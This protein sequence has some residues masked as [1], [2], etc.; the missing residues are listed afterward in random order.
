MKT[1]LKSIYI[2][3][4]TLFAFGCSDNSSS[5]SSGSTVTPQ[6]AYITD[7]VELKIIDVA[8][9]T[10]PIFVNSIAI[11][12]SYFVSVSPNVAYVA[13][14]DAVASYISLVDISNPSTPLIA[15]T[16]AKDNTLAFSLLSDMYTVNGVGYITDTYR[17]LHVV[18]IANSTFSS[19]VNLGG[20]AMSVTKIQNKLFVIDQANGLH[21]YDITVPGS[22]AVTGVTNNTDI[23][24]G[25]YGDS[26]FG[27][28]HSWVETDGTFLY[29]ANTIDKKIKQ[30]DAAT[31]TLINEVSI[32]GYPT[33]FAIHNGFAYVTMK[34]SV[35][36]PLQTSYDG[37]R[38]YDLAS[39][40]LID[41]KP[42]SKTSG[43]ALN[44]NNAYVTDSNGL[45][46]YDISSNSFVLQSSLPIGSGNFIALGQ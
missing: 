23:D 45:H 25:S 2:V 46:I 37:V 34:A 6:Y 33:A 29:V 32:E 17:G 3:A 24:T 12:T 16:I 15:S 38:M 5:S 22:P 35:N 30:F 11:N 43:I 8:T 18:D 4:I 10:V 28:Y 40:S 19:Q 39:L 44:G 42:L 21:S 26:P 27:Q 31:L 7:G 41:M 20:D 1:I 36:A 13:Q 9:P 14:Y